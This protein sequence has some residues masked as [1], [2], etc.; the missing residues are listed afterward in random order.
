MNNRWKL[1]VL[2]AVLL[3]ATLPQASRANTWCGILLLKSKQSDVRYLSGNSIEFGQK[4][5]YNISYCLW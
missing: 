5:T 1:Q 3:F 2:M 4:S